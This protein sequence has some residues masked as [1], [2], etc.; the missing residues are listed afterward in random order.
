MEHNKKAFDEYQQAVQNL[1]AIK[2][3]AK[4]SPITLMSHKETIIS[5][6]ESLQM[7]IITLQKTVNK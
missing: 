1:Q 3:L 5:L 7:Q 2:M 4:C 6:L